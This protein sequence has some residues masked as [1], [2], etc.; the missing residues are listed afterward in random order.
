MST[1]DALV[2]RFQILSDRK[3]ALESKAVEPKTTYKEETTGPSPDPKEKFKVRD[4]KRPTNATSWARAGQHPASRGWT[5]T[6]QSWSNSYQ[7]GR[8]L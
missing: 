7:Q 8:R 1:V 2:A 6:C 5:E 3:R 4:P